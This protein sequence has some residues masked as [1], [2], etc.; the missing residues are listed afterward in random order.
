MKVPTF[1]NIGFLTY[2]ETSGNKV[3]ELEMGNDERDEHGR[4][5]R[6]LHLLL[7]P[8][9]YLPRPMSLLPMSQT[10]HVRRCSS[11]SREDTGHEPCWTQKQWG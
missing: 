6:S 1:E 2:P 9:Y 8:Q 3:L 4:P 11:K 5:L 10:S 7:S